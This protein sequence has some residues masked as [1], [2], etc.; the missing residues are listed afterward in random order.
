MDKLVDNLKGYKS[1]SKNNPFLLRGMNRAL[2]RIV[3]AVNCREKIVIYGYYDFDGIAAISL[4]L[5]VLKFLNA[6]V[7]YFIPDYLDKDRN[8]N[9]Y[10]IKN[11]INFLGAGLII[12]VGCGINSV[13]QVE[14]CNKLDIDTIIT[15]Y[16]KCDSVLP[17]CIVVNPNQIGCSYPFKYLSASGVAHKL[18][19]AMSLYYKMKCVNK[20]MDLVMLG[21][22][23]NHNTI[24]EENLYILKQ[25]L[26]ALANT[27]N[28]G[29]KALLKA[30][31]IN[32]DNIDVYDLKALTHSISKVTLPINKIDNA[33]IV[34]E[35][36]TTTNEDRANQIAK[37]L[38]NEIYFNERNKI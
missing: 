27:N 32:K 13:E 4:L 25:G 6:D 1:Y 33:R 10:Y 7:E 28:Y 36:F 34:V 12:T 5:L 9:S 30:N 3:K 18:V 24:K 21:T 19:E 15:D 2:D 17:N 14:L 26:E 11:H 38:K 16:H 8:I 23:S 29:L 37:Y 20:F 22:I 31:N 35:L